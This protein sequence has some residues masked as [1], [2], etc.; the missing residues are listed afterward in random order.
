RLLPGSFRSFLASDLLS[1]RGKLNLLLERVRPRR[2][3]AEDES[4]DAFVRRRA[5]REAAEILADTF[6]TGIHAGDP[7]LLSIR[8]AFPRLA[9]MEEKHGSVLKGMAQAAR[10]RR[11]QS[12]IDRPTGKMWSFRE[13]LR[14]LVESLSA[15]L[16]RPPIHGVAVQR[17]NRLRESSGERWI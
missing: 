14:V 13:G 12:G 16:P 17:I 6:V 4:I 10:E 15:Q 1:W 2:R 5:G 11:A 8:A 9:A 7:S 3:D